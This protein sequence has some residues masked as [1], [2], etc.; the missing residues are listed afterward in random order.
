MPAD[1]ELLYQGCCVIFDSDLLIPDEL[2]SSSASWL[3]DLFLSS[4][5]ISRRAQTRLVKGKQ[6]SRLTP[7]KIAGK[8]TI[9][10]DCLLELHLRNFVQQQKSQNLDP[11][12]ESLQKEACS[13]V[14]NAETLSPAPSNIFKHFLQRAILGSSRWIDPFRARSEALVMDEGLNSLELG[15]MPLVMP[16]SARPGAEDLRLNHFESHSQVRLPSDGSSAPRK[17]PKP[18]PG[19]AKSRPEE[20]IAGH[21]D[22][23]WLT[24]MPFFLSGE[25][26][27][28]RLSKDLSRFVAASVS[29]HNPKRHVPTD[30]ELR[31]QA[32]WIVYDEYVDP[33][34]F[35][36]VLLTLALVRFTLGSGESAN[37]SRVP[38]VTTHGTKRRQT[39]LCGC[40]SS[41]AA[42]AC[43]QMTV[44]VRAW[45]VRGP[46]V[47]S[48]AGNQDLP[49]QHYQGRRGCWAIWLKQ[50]IGV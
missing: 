42:L 16:T 21:D 27:Y 31:H 37:R 3:R 10:Q 40:V 28:L 39:T 6:K 18:S 50:V 7:L 22:D 14:E 29:S 48:R 44:R 32:R 4:D 1:E 20:Q 26:S 45:L 5:E 12:D 49:G 47:W 19:R 38:L 2:V 43:L 24:S 11:E 17:T 41:S 13:I 36:S 9:F 35:C 25:N 8:A 23:V 34:P 30:E 33:L 46:R 15:P